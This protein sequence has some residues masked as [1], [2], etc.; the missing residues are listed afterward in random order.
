MGCSLIHMRF[1]SLSSLK[2]KRF[3]FGAFF[4]SLASLEKE[5]FAY[6]LLNDKN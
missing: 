3:E 5:Q 6:S 2:V 1:I 4:A